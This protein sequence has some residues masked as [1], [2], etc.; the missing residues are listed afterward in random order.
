MEQPREMPLT[1]TELEEVGKGVVDDKSMLDVLK[2]AANYYDKRE[3]KQP[4]KRS[5]EADF[6]KGNVRNQKCPVCDKKMKKC[7][8]GVKTEI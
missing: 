5:M 6:S 4:I 3:K 8:C 7:H 2:K 1:W